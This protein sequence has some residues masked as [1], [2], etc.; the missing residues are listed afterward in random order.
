MNY[1]GLTKNTFIKAIDSMDDPIAIIKSKGAR[2]RRNWIVITD[3]VDQ[4][5]KHI[6]VPFAINQRQG[7]SGRINRVKS[8]YGKINLQN[9]FKE[10][11]L[12]DVDKIVYITPNKNKHKILSTKGIQFP[13]RGYNSDAFC[14]LNIPQGESLSSNK[15][16]KLSIVDM[17]NKAKERTGNSDTTFYSANESVN[18]TYKLV[19][20]NSLA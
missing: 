15:K 19:D 4:N 3:V 20:A 9:F 10:T 12:E 13:N 5:N 6:I 7:R 2:G 1:H 18:F 14:S 16:K 8:I 11:L 17:T